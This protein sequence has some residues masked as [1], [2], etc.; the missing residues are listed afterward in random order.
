M[1]ALTATDASDLSISGNVAVFAA[2]LAAEGENSSTTLYVDAFA[3]EGQLSSAIV[4]GQ[5][6]V[7]QVTDY[8]SY[9]GTRSAD[10]IRTGDA[11]SLVWGE[12]GKDDIRAG[13][14]DDWL[15][16]GDGKDKITAG[17]GHDGL[18]GGVG[19]DS[20]YG[21]EGD[22]WLFGGRNDD[23]LSGGIGDDMLLGGAGEDTIEGGAGNDLIEGGNGRDQLSG[24]DGDDLFRLGA[25]RG[26]DD[27][28][29]RGGRGADL[30]LITDRFDD[31]VILDFRIAEGD[32]LIGPGG[33]WDDPATLNRYNGMIVS[34]SRSQRDADDLEIAFRFGSRESILTLDEFFV[35]N[36][37]CASGFPRRGIASDSQAL[38]LLTDIFGDHDGLNMAGAINQLAIGN[39]ISDMG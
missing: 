6:A 13:A 25:P 1:L 30:W 28:V 18:Y 27:D 21:D 2:N 14:G 16:A 22:D 17:A 36:P 19:E 32:Q 7:M 35:L 26:D 20:L 34:L 23:L 37:A 12:G 10:N 11:A 4:S 29:F 15:F 9:T 38:Q 31:D 24:G 3:Y 33:G 5:A 39:I 8:I